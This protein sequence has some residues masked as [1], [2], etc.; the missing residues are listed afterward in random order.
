VKHQP[1]YVIQRYR[2][3]AFSFVWALDESLLQLQLCHLLHQY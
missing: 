2:Y 3:A 1:S